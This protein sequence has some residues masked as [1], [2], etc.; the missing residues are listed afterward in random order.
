MPLTKSFMFTKTKITDTCSDNTKI[1]F[2]GL[3]D[4]LPLTKSVIFTKTKITD[5]CSDNTK[6]ALDYL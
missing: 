4:K 5:T 6:I 1:A 3:T 2:K